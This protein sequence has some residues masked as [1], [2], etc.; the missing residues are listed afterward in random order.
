MSGQGS[1]EAGAP[2]GSGL[3]VAIV[4]SRWHDPVMSG[5]LAAA[6]RACD[7]ADAQHTVTR[8]PGAFEVPVVAAELAR[9][10]DAVVALATVVR[11]GTPHFE[12]VCHAVTD[13][14]LRVCLDTGT[15]VGFGVLTCYS[16]AEALD[17]AGLPDSAEDKG[18]EATLAAIETALLLARLRS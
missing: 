16:D 14:L 3:V 17:R 5:L 8:V 2:D 10:A 6:V 7:E 11:G 4:A 1:Y 18:R 12:Y 13:G 15:P 9:S